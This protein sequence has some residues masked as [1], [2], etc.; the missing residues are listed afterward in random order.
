MIK[1]S[2]KSRVQLNPN[3]E[4]YSNEVAKDNKAN[5]VWL[6]PNGGSYKH[7]A[8]M[9]TEVRI[10]KNKDSK[11]WLNQQGKDENIELHESI[12]PE[13]QESLQAELHESLNPQGKD[14]N[15]ELQDNNIVPEVTEVLE[16]QESLQDEL[17]SHLKEMEENSQPV[18]EDT[19]QNDDQH[20]QEELVSD[21]QKHNRRSRLPFW[22]SKRRKKTNTM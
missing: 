13:V 19:I 1:K 4:G 10:F 20:Q 16:V 6:N 12:L 21:T 17:H 9:Q 5:Q 7:P 2:R 14:E 18:L 15:L 11:V 22:M 8:S 3:Q